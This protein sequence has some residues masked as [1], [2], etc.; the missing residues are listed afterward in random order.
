MVEAGRI[1]TGDRHLCKF[2]SFSLG[3]GSKFAKGLASGDG[4]SKFAKGLASVLG[5][6]VGSGWY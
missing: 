6:G 3:G 5:P 4:G 2:I 1:D